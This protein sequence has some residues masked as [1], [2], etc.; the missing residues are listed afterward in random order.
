MHV[1]GCILNPYGTWSAQKTDRSCKSQAPKVTWS[2]AQVIQDVQDKVVQ[3]KLKRP[4]AESAAS[5]PRVADD[6]QIN[7]NM[8]DE[9]RLWLLTKGERK[10]QRS[11]LAS[12]T[13]VTRKA[14]SGGGLEDIDI[15]R[16]PAVLP[17][18]TAAACAGVLAQPDDCAGILPRDDATF[19]VEY[20]GSIAASDPTR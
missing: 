13:Q 10:R 15:I 18:Y 12:A 20:F 11:V 3:N 6:F 9:S 19:D 8:F 17:R 14:A 4:L 2:I 16:A 5:G 7:N 1:Q